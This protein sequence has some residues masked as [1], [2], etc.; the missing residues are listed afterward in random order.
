MMPKIMKRFL[1]GLGV[2]LAGAAT[3]KLTASQAVPNSNVVIESVK[4][5]E[6]DKVTPVAAPELRL[7]DMTGKEVSL[8]DYKGRVVVLN[9]WATW[10]PP[11]RK[12]IP[13]FIEL[14][15]NYGEQGLQFIGVAMDEEGAPKI[16]AYLDK[17]PIN[18]PIWVGEAGPV[19][20]KFGALNAIPVTYLIDRQGMIRAKYVGIRKKAVVE[21][22]IRPLLAEK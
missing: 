16:Q 5:T 10:C 9:F 4:S 3:Y 7:K 6:E 19:Q 17:Q 12:E 14:Q 8:S 2:M 21:E 11:C 22:M 20:E 18:Y 13:D 1:I 15:T